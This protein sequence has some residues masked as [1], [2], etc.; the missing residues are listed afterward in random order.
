MLHF[1]QKKVESLHAKYISLILIPLLFITGCGVTDVENDTAVDE[2][3]TAR[4]DNCNPDT[5]INTLGCF[6]NTAE[7]GENERITEGF[8]NLYAKRG[9]ESENKIA[10]YDTYLFGYQFTAD[11]LVKRRE[12]TINYLY[13]VKEWGVDEAGNVLAVTLDGTY[14]ISTRFDNNTA[15]YEVKSSYLGET[16]KL[17]HESAVDTQNSNAYGY[18]GE[19]IKFGNYSFGNYTAAASWTVSEYGSSTASIVVLATHQLL[20]DGTTNNGGM[21]GVSEDGKVLTINGVSYLPFKYPD[22]NCV[23]AFEFDGGAE[24]KLVNLCTAG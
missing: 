7:F 15:C 18:Y 11:G 1:Q 12:A 6:G 20:A 17:C 14:T 13:G 3:Y 24:T 22:T 5:Y 8:W 16:L 4:E 21:W 2:D 19:N 9:D 23:V 10:N